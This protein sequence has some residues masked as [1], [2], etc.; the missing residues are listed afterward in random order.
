M[1]SSSTASSLRSS[2]PTK[3]ALARENKFLRGRLREVEE[4][5]RKMKIRM[6]EN[7]LWR[8]EEE[9]EEARRNPWRTPSP[10]EGRFPRETSKRNLEEMVAQVVNGGKKRK[11]GGSFDPEKEV[12]RGMPR[13]VKVGGVRWEEG[14]GGVE[15]ALREAGVGFCDG[16]RWLVGEEELDKRRKRGGLASTVVVRV[17]GEEVER[18]LNR[19]GLWVGGYWCSVKRFVAVKP[20]RKEAGWMRVV[21]TIRGDVEVVLKDGKERD[22]REEREREKRGIALGQGIGLGKVELKDLSDKVGKLEKVILS[23]GRE[24]ARK[25][26]D[27]TREDDRREKRSLISE[28]EVVKKEEKKEERSRVSVFTPGMEWK[29]SGPGLFG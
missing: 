22:K 26:G 15:N 19:A 29:P 14:I 13:M 11:V 4:E 2:L 17:R 1:A 5:L 10:E 27:W 16:T 23:L 20:K 3:D 6:G 25:K 9:E 28:E 12:G 18:Q 8:G 21:D 7:R 24:L